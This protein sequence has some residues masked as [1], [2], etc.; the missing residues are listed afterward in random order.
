MATFLS[1]HVRG[2]PPEP[3]CHW[4]RRAGNLIDEGHDQWWPITRDSG[5]WSATLAALSEVVDKQV[6]HL[7]RA[8][9]RDSWLAESATVVGQTRELLYAGILSIELGLVDDAREISRQLLTRA[10]G[11]PTWGR[12][13]EKFSALI[14]PTGPSGA[15][16]APAVEGNGRPDG[17]RLDEASGTPQ[18]SSTTAIKL[19]SETTGLGKR[20]KAPKA[21]FGRVA[22]AP[23]N[24][25]LTGRT[26]WAIEFELE[27]DQTPSIVGALRWATFL[28][29]AETGALLAGWSG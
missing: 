12:A 22:L 20:G 18:I 9:L 26:V 10:S 1:E 15:I 7:D 14:D 2:Q 24:P 11:S 6:V 17:L 27:A 23:G 4:R 3:D 29:D 25:R 21:R 28:V 13:V 8:R 19:A 5:S 16:D